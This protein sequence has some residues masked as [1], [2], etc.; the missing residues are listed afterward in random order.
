MR[1]GLH[2]IVSS[3]ETIVAI[4]TPFGRSGIGV[5]R[6]SGPAAVSITKSFFKPHSSDRAFEHRNAIVGT[7]M[8]LSNETLD[9]VVVTFFQAP[10]S[11][12]GE[13]VVEISAHGNPLI[14]GRIVETTRRGGA[15]IATPGEFTLRA[16]ANGKMD[17]I[18][19]EAVREF[20]D[21]QTEQQARTALRQMEGA[22][23]QRIR[24][25]KAQLVDVIAHLEAGIDFAEDD[26]DVPDNSS[27]A[28]QIHP[29]V[30]QLQT[31]QETFGYGRILSAGLRIAILGKPNVG[32]SS[33]FNR[34]VA[35]DRAIVTDI[36]GTTRDVLTETI[37]LDGVP[38]RLADTA[39]VRQ[40]K[41][42]V[43]SI[44]VNRTFETLA[45][46][47]LAL[48][49]LDGAGKLDDDDRQVMAKSEGVRHLVVINKKDLPQ[50]MDEKT[51]NGASRVHVSAA[52]GEGM[53]ELWN[54][55]RRTISDQHTDLSDEFVLTNAR[56]NDAI[57][58]AIEGLHRASDALQ[59]KVPH[60]MVL[61]D[62]YQGLSALDELTGE[63]VTDDILDRIFS[64][65]CIG[66]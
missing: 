24:P 7:W 4:S 41:D 36:P 55:I 8:T 65:F 3:D 33:L 23:S 31:L 44:G 53:D 60:E 42:R 39:G 49:V 35:S 57:L 62:L 48:V 9:E 21:A 25:V 58:K 54:A 27:I 45:D 13:D 12:T 38:L 51:L 11:Y 2:R 37:S 6:L 29:L 32:K 28:D 14:L 16:V 43:E 18:Q 22:L 20:I 40:S 47:D 5:I 10:H 50:V 64:T 19:A 59:E 66:K 34:L 46:A 61:L 30:D 17:L 26:V 15:R 63:S 1:E 56:Q 52:T